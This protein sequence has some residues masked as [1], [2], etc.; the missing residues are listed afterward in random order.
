[1]Y[2]DIDELDEMVDDDEITVEEEGFML[3]YLGVV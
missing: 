3:G 1:M 2:I